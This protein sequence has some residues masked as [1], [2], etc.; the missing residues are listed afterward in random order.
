[1]AAR[2][3]VLFECD[4]PFARGASPHALE[5]LVRGI[6]AAWRETRAAARFTRAGCGASRPRATRTQQIQGERLKAQRLAR[7]ATHKHF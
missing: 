1:V 4:Q 7:E 2:F 5:S 6:E 3:S